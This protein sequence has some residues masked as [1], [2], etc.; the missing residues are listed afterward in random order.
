MTE[1]T[2]QLH[3]QDLAGETRV[4][5]G[6]IGMSLMEIIRSS[7]IDDIPAF[8]GGCCSCASCHVHVD[9]AFAS[10]LPPMSQDED[11][12]LEG[13][14]H[15]SAGSRLSCQIPASVALSGIR[16]SIAPQE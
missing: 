5:E 1:A 6:E 13:S 3:V 15:R 14:E 9:P 16:L 7:G 11:D 4:I 8:C 2:I 10:T 12:L